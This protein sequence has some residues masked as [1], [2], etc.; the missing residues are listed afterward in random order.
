MLSEGV[1]LKTGLKKCEEFFFLS[2]CRSH[3]SQLCL[4]FLPTWRAFVASPSK[5]I[6]SRIVFA[7]L[8]FGCRWDF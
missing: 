7:V 3:R 2:N 4:R 6:F 1:V 5:Q 8:W